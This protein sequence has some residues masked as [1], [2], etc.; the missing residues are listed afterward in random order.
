MAILQYTYTTLAAAMQSWP[1]DDGD[2]Y[3]TEIPNLINMG[4]FNLLSEFNLATFDGNT[5]ASLVASAG[6][7]TKPLTVIAALALSYTNG[8]LYQ[9][10]SRM[11]PDFVRRYNAEAVAGSPKYY[12]EEDETTWTLAPIPNFSSVNGLKIRG[13]IRPTMLDS[14]S[15]SGTSWLSRNYPQLLLLSCLMAGYQFLKNDQRWGMA[16]TEYDLKLPDAKAEVAQL[17]RVSPDDQLV[18]REVIRPQNNDAP[19]QNQ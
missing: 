5:S 17:R 10:L 7:I 16:K 1:A 4:E 8:G 9:Q 19:P 14:A 6:S 3:I 12:A 2:A 11:S 18:A 15:G 13:V